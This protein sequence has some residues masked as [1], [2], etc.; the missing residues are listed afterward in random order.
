MYVHDEL[1]LYH[2]M[3]TLALILGF[4][5]EEALSW[6]GTL[7]GCPPDPCEH[8]PDADRG[9]REDRSKAQESGQ[10]RGDQGQ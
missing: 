8:H 5:R 1:L 4:L 9:H 7:P 6:L 3:A 10:R 2:K